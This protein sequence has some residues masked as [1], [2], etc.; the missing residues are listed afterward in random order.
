[1]ELNGP[2]Q[3]TVE[4]LLFLENVLNFSTHNEGKSIYTFGDGL[5]LTVK[6]KNA[7]ITNKINIPTRIS[8]IKKGKNGSINLLVPTKRR[9]DG[10][11]S[12]KK[13]YGRGTVVI[14]KNSV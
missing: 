7:G 3:T 13:S 11:T 12:V 4:E 8:R 10:K 5:E 6:L 1:M 2:V 9:P 14:V